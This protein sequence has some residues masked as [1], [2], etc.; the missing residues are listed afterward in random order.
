LENPSASRPE[1]AIDN[2]YFFYGQLPRQEADMVDIA[3]FANLTAHRSRRP[4]L[5]PS[6]TLL[7]QAAFGACYTFTLALV[8]GMI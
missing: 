8:L 1:L 3:S 5:A 4:F 7:P 6:E 2:A